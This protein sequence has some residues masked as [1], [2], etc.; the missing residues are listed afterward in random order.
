[1]SFAPVP[2]VIGFLAFLGGYLVFSAVLIAIGSAVPTA[3]EASSFFGFAIILMFIPF[4]AFAAITT[5]PE[6]II[7]KVFTFFPLTAPITLMLRNAVGNLSLMEA[8]ISLSILLVCV[9]I[10]MKL[11]IR[12]F[13]YGT[14]EYNR[15]LGLRELL[16]RKAS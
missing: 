13:G 8:A 12:A 5:S 2:I 14:L 16:A 7:V 6:Q 3:K 1:L 4:Y 11:A 9:V 10:G 15:R